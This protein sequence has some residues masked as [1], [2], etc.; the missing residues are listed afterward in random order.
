MSPIEEYIILGGGT[1]GALVVVGLCVGLIID[2]LSK[3]KKDKLK[4]IK[5]IKGYIP[6]E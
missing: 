5:E 3:R 1:V 4:K 2:S 6:I